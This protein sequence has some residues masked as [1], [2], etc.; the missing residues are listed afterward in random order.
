MRLIHTTDG[1][2]YRRW[3]NLIPSLLLPGSAQFLSGRRSAGV[4]WFLSF[5]VLVLTIAGYLVSPW[6]AYSVVTMGPFDWVFLGVLVAVAGDGF[7]RPI[8]RGLLKGWFA[9][10]CAWV[11]FQIALALAVR[12]FLIQ[13]FKLPTGAMQPTLMGNRVDADGTALYGDHFFVSKLAYGHSSPQRGDVVVFKTKGI[14]FNGV[15]Q[16]TYYIKRIAGLPGETIGIDPPYVVVNGAKLTEPPIFR[17]IAEGKNGFAGYCV[18][19]KTAAGAAPL[20]TPL[21][22]IVLG[23]EE[24]LV[25]GDNSSHSLDGRYYGPI[26]R[27]AIIG[28]AVYIYAPAGRKGRIE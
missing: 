15:K 24:Y 19:V 5:Q 26:R 17:A 2:H 10:L 14:H 21:D 22:R 3:V 1:L 28:K 18:A 11:V 12:A 27:S 6:S 9:V 13:P 8:R 7:R 20:A 25:L 16:D 23:P 4:V